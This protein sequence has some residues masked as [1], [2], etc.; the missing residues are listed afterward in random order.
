M[1]HGCSQ[2]RFRQDTATHELTVVQDDGVHRH[3]R[4][5]RPGTYCYGF[6]IVTWPGHLAISGDMGAAVFTRLPDMFEF[7]RGAPECTPTGQLYIN[8]GYWAEKCVANDGPQKEFVP[9]QFRACVRELFDTFRKDESPAVWLADEVWN[10]IEDD[11]LCAHTTEEAVGNMVNFE[12]PNEL[13]FSF[14][15]AWEYSRQLEDYTFHFVW[16]LYAIAYAVG[17]YDA[18]KEAKASGE[19]L[20]QQTGEANG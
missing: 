15:D 16:R 2:D 1:S 6:D 10:R 7:F 13:K 5:R 12:S 20:E 11:V 19:V 9:E 18:L 4:F 14:V 17:A 3:L 8:T